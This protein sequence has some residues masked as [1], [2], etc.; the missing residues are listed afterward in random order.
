M[1]STIIFK[2]L[3]AGLLVSTTLFYSCRKTF[4][5]KFIADQNLSNSTNAQLFVAMVNATRNYVFVDGN[6]VTGAL[7]S[8]GSVFPT[9]GYG[10]AVTPGIRSFLVADTQT[11]R[12]PVTTQIPYTFASNM[13]AAKNYTIFIYDTITSPKQ[14]TV[15]TDIVIPSDSTARLRFANFLYSPFGLPNVDVYSRRRAGNIFTNIAVTDVSGFIP[16]QSISNT[17][18]YQPGSIDTLE[19]RQTGT[20]T[21]LAVLNGFNP[22]QKRSYT[23]V[24]RGSGLAVG[25]NGKALSLFLNY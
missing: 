3:F 14:K 22:T 4:D 17:V 16:V 9:T 13:Q 15:L 11:T 24:L 5:S 21:N 6:P 10:F 1:K 8:S 18:A 12:I 25:T 20:L 23:I 7:L 2:S 19:V